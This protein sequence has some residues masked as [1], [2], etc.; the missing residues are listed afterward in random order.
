[1]TM[2]WGS[3]RTYLSVVGIFI[4]TIFTVSLFNS[5][6]ALADKENANRI[7]DSA[8]LN[9]DGD[10]YY[11]QGVNQVPDGDSA[12]YLNKSKQNY[13]FE[14]ETITECNDLIVIEGNPDDATHGKVFKRDR[15]GFSCRVKDVI[16]ITIDNGLSKAMGERKK[17]NDALH[18]ALVDKAYT[19]CSSAQPDKEAECEKNLQTAFDACSDQLG[20]GSGTARFTHDIDQNQLNQCIAQKTGLSVDQVNDALT[21][22]L[23]DEVNPQCNV[24]GVGWLICQASKLMAK[25]TDGAFAL[26]KQLLKVPGLGVDTPGGQTMYSRWAII[27][28]IANVVFVLIFLY[29]IYSQVTGIGLDNYGIKRLLPRLIVAVILTNI[30]YYI[31]AVM[32][33]ITNVLGASLRDL[34]MQV[35]LPVKPEFNGWNQV[36]SA[37]L[38]IAGAVALYLSIA[39]LIPVITSGFIAIL[40]TVI[41]LIARQA[42]IVLLIIISPIAFVLNVLPNTQRWFERWWSAFFMILMMYPVIAV[43]YGGSQV[44]AGVISAA[45]PDQSTQI[46]F[47]ILALG[48]QTVPLFTVPL[49]MKA[50][51]GLF[52]RFS[53][54]VNKPTKGVFDRMRT[55]SKDKADELTKKRDINA[56]TKRDGKG[57]RSPYARLAKRR[58]NRDFA[59]DYTKEQLQGDAKNAFLSSQGVANDIAEAGAA[60]SVSMSER[61]PFGDRHRQAMANKQATVDEIAEQLEQTS[62]SVEVSN[63]EA[64]AAVLEDEN[65]ST[66]DLERLYKEGKTKDNGQAT[67]AAQAAAARQLA[68]EGK[69]ERIHDLLRSLKEMEGSNP[70]RLM[71]E[72]VATGIQEGHAQNGAAHLRSTSNV[73]AIRNGA[74]FQTDGDVVDGLYR[75]A[76]ASD[77]YNANSVAM[78]SSQSLRGLRQAMENGA[79]DAEHSTAIRQSVAASQQSDRLRT[80]MSGAAQREASRF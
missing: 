68:R 15:S 69:Q 31:C 78:E 1:M 76:A 45:N 24:Q 38:I 55:K 74:A 14:E 7:A 46:I 47:A 37:A 28:N 70:S 39:V 50:G 49:I 56:V 43:I 67:E 19:V 48:V 10:T 11:W 3:Y 6:I 33:D 41:L 29:V 60:G 64:E 72:A 65:Y 27:R 59:A 18:Q 61:L 75:S 17:T 23:S 80:K 53:G 34:L 51:G 66:A 32:V 73:A 54:V 26:L 63:M 13:V 42:L 58:S 62:F 52:E 2:S 8:D 12:N 40:M 77:A 44:A 35:A 57:G 4:V 25:I 22:S 36:T 16:D 20:G 9:M 21:P 71:R 79:I 30:S 5:P